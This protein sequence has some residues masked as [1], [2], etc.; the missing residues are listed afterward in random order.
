M[1]YIMIAWLK[2]TSVFAYID[3]RNEL[4]NNKPINIIENDQDM[5]SIPT[6]I[7]MNSYPNPFNPST[8]I[9]YN[10]PITGNVKLE[11]Y[12]VRGQLIKTLVNERMD[13]GEHTIEWNGTDNTSRSVSSGI[14]FSR[15]TSGNKTAYSKM[16]LMK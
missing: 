3:K 13:S 5:P 7:T 15:L 4:L 1:K 6:I 16:L 11:I 2:P 8:T 9:R 14:Y 12:N 10:L